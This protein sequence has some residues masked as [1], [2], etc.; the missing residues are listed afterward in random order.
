MMYRQGLGLRRL[1]LGDLIDFSNKKN[2]ESGVGQ[3]K[4]LILIAATAN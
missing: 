1:I 4:C 3:G 2:V